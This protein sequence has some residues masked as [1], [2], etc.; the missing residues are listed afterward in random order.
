MI[1]RPEQKQLRNKW[2]IFFAISFAL[3]VALLTLSKCVH[4]VIV[5][6]S[7]LTL[8]ICSDV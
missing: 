1:D 6:T 3:N 4:C 8:S 5:E 2:K 7:W